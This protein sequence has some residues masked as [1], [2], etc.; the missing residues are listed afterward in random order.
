MAL[1][2]SNSSAHIPFHRKDDADSTQSTIYS[3]TGY[4]FRTIKEICSIKWETPELVQSIRFPNFR[5][6]KVLNDASPPRH[7]I[8]GDENG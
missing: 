4:D 3:Y 7:S 5:L 6:Y 2:R 8:K 1:D